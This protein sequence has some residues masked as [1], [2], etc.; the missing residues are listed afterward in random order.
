[1]P[2][3]RKSPL[4][5]RREHAA[6]GAMDTEPLHPATEPASQPEFESV[7]H[8]H[9]L[10]PLRRTALRTLQV[11]VGKLCNQACH[12]CHVEAGPK[13]TEIMPL[14]VAERVAALLATSPGVETVDLTGG[15]PELNPTFRFLVESA[16]RLGR[17]VIDRCNLTVLLEPGLD[18]VPQFLADNQVEVVCSLPC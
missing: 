8:R 10:G 7:L 2:Q 13:R 9:G 1:M 6:D 12:H 5:G 18:W 16:R 4:A 3:A 17:R 15:A 14:A 11:N